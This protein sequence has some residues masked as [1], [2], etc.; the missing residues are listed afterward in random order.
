MVALVGVARG[1]LDRL[2]L[3][4]TERTLKL[5]ADA[6]VGAADLVQVGRVDGKDKDRKSKR[7][8]AGMRGTLPSKE[9]VKQGRLRRHKAGRRGE[10]RCPGEQ[11]ACGGA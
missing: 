11:W 6:Y 9:H 5:E 10:I 7:T 4:Q 2:F 8:T 1:E 3:T